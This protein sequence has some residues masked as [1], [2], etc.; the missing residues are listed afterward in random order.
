MEKI[1]LNTTHPEPVLTVCPHSAISLVLQFLHLTMNLE[2][3]SAQLPPL[4]IL[5]LEYGVDPEIAFLAHRPLLMELFSATSPPPVEEL[6]E[7]EQAA[8]DDAT[9]GKSIFSPKCVLLCLWNCCLSQ[10][11]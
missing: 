4:D 10:Q 11:Y 8:M 7:G 3:Y 9:Q 6:E 5:R 2:E 1:C